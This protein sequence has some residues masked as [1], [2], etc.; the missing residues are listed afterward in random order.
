MAAR[1]LGYSVVV[2]SAIEFT[3]ELTGAAT[4]RIP[5]E[6]AARLPKSG[7]ARIV[8]LTADDLAAA[9]WQ[10]AAYGQF[11]RDDA[12]DDAIYDTLR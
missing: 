12:E 4:L 10:S 5:P 2:M 11:L 1:G 6:V 7:M 9:D 8:V 3:T